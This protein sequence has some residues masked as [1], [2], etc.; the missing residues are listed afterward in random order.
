MGNCCKKVK[1][2]IYPNPWDGFVIESMRYNY[3]SYKVSFDEMYGRVRPLVT[4]AA[5]APSP[6]STPASQQSA[7]STPHLQALT[8]SLQPVSEPLTEREPLLRNV[9]T[10]TSSPALGGHYK[11]LTSSP[12]VLGSAAG[13]APPPPF[14]LLDITMQKKIH[15]E[16]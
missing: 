11:S 12:L 7:A 14:S 3:K 15:I 13:P 8:P 5:A 16:Y 10:P 9:L 2:W 1:D 6:A 4:P